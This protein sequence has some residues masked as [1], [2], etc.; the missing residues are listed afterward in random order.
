MFGALAVRCNYYRSA[1]IKI[2]Q[3]VDKGRFNIFIGGIKIT[4]GFLAINKKGFEVCLPVTWR[5][6]SAVVIKYTCLV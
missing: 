4:F 3:V 2:L 1:S 5:E 6:N